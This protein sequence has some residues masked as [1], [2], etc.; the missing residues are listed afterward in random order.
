MKDETLVGGRQRRRLVHEAIIAAGRAG[1][2]AVPAE[3][4]AVPSQRIRV[5]IVD[6]AGT[7]GLIYGAQRVILS[8][9]KPL[10][11]DVL[12]HAAIPY[13]KGPFASRIHELGVAVHVHPLRRALFLARYTFGEL[14]RREPVDL[15]H[16]HDLRASAIARPVCAALG[17]PVVTTYHENLQH[18][19]LRGLRRWRRE[20]AIRCDAD[21]VDL[22][23]ANVCV[24]QAIGDELVR[25]QRVRPDR[26]VVIPNG[27]DVAALRA[28]ASEAAVAA[29]RQAV[30]LTAED[31][32][33]VLLGALTHRKGQHLLLEAAPAVLA[34]HPQAVFVFVGEGEASAGLQAQAAALGIAERVRFAGFQ[35]PSTA[36]LAMA[37][38]VAMPSLEEGLPMVALE[39]MALGRPLVASHAGGLPEVVV[40][41][42]TGLLVPT[43]TVEPL[44]AGLIAL[45]DDAGERARLGHHAAT[46]VDL[47]FTLERTTRD[48]LAV[49]QR[50][51][52]ETAT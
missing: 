33:I 50:V 7:R 24:S 4:G 10:S 39:A 52:A 26:V 35:D 38:V 2:N 13:A 41:G 49:Y 29:A 18:A 20:L 1:D 43:G 30:G 48:L 8:A 32:P 16:T 28:G 40:D 47:R 42:E 34:R 6:A 31:R 25:L 3:A 5:L 14:L 19:H 44:A 45:L 12:W 51:L 11:D 36:F 21:T 37:A 9:I 23:Q 17:V 27:V 15:V 46:R 22:P